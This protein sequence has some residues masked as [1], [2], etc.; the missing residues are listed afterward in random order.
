MELLIGA[1][2]GLIAGGALLLVEYLVRRREKNQETEEQRIV[3]FTN[4]ERKI[5]GSIFNYL[6]P[7][8][9]IELMKSELGP[10]NKKSKEQLGLFYDEVT[11]DTVTISDSNEPEEVYDVYVYFF[12]NA[13]VK[14]TSKD[15]ETIESLTVLTNDKDISFPVFSFDAETR[16]GLLNVT[17]VT[18]DIV[19]N[20]R[21]QEFQGCR[22][23][24]TALQKPV[25]MPYRIYVTYFCDFLSGNSEKDITKNP[26]HLIGSVIEGVCYSSS[27]ET[28]T[29]IFVEDTV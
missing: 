19:E 27:P 6:G 18:A 28:S 3:R 25:G 22:N 23:I 14:I 15:G 12:K 17:T 10:P 7:R 5:T 11:N 4:E 26:E 20:S 1:A 16:G 29:Y 13:S 21:A 9:S 8:S 2:G 24:F